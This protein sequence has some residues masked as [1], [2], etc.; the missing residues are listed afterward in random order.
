MIE[1]VLFYV[2]F[3]ILVYKLFRCVNFRKQATKRKHTV[4][5][6]DLIDEPQA[7]KPRFQELQVMRVLPYTHRSESI[8]QN[9]IQDDIAVFDSDEDSDFDGMSVTTIDAVEYFNRDPRLRPR[10]VN[11]SDNE[12]SNNS[13][14]AGD[15]DVSDNISVS[16][17]LSQSSAMS[18]SSV[19]SLGSNAGN[20][21]ILNQNVGFWPVYTHYPFHDKYLKLHL[22]T[23][24]CACIHFVQTMYVCMFY[25]FAC[26]HVCVT[27]LICFLFVLLRCRRIL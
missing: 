8:D 4:D 9:D 11:D 26:V 12:Q 1:N 20:I 21:R 25:V 6:F 16:S 14:D 3:V 19:S 27:V 18:I 24:F 17:E 15:Y 10:S 13:S 2:C 5:A 22:F 7:K 23:F